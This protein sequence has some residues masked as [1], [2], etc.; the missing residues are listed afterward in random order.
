MGGFGSGGHN[1]KRAHI[2]GQPRLHARLLKQ[3]NLLAEGIRA[4]MSWQDNWGRQTAAI[5]VIGGAQQVTLAYSVR[6][7]DQSPWR[8][9]EEPVRILR[10]ARPFGGEQVF[11]ACPG[12]RRRVMSIALS[13]GRFRCRTCHGLTYASSQEGSTDRA[14]RRANK[15]RRRL[16]CEPGWEAPYWKPKHMRQRTFN[17]IEEQIEAAEAEVTDAHI[18]LLN[19]L[20]RVSRP[21]ARSAGRS[22]W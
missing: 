10:M 4:C 11:I 8:R 5:E 6:S 2:E 17:W 15:L 18:R 7:N 3:R 1:R 21:R 19:R 14:M 13:G 9:V 22:F 16:G 20:G 12:C